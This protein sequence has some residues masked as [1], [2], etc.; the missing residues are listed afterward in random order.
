MVQ[1]ESSVEKSG[2]KLGVELIGTTPKERGTVGY[3]S[4]DLHAMHY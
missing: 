1:K 2:E 3:R 4:H